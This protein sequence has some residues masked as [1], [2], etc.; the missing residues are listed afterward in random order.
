[1]HNKNGILTV[2]SVTLSI[3]L[4]LYIIN[5]HTNLDDIHMDYED[6]I[7]RLIEHYESTI[8]YIEEKHKRDITHATEPKINGT[9]TIFRDNYYLELEKDEIS[10]KIITIGKPITEC[11]FMARFSNNSNDSWCSIGLINKGKYKY[12]AFEKR[13]GIDFRAMVFN[14]SQFLNTLSTQYEELSSDFKLNN[15]Y[16]QT[17]FFNKYKISVFDN[18]VEFYINNKKVANITENIPKDENLY[19][20][21]QLS[22]LENSIL[23]NE[24]TYVEV[25]DIKI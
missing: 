14:K 12:A 21:I 7:N 24:D 17:G 11:S 19:F 20:H 22:N 16:N 2:I 9:Y 5:L 8:K 25:K 13:Y 15:Y 6:K 1:M 18:Y 10:S 3:F 23:L 4:F